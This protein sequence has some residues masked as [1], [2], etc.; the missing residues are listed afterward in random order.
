MY[1]TGLVVNP[2]SH[3]AREHCER[4]F[5]LGNSKAVE[6]MQTLTRSHIARVT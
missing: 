1:A 4:A 3:R 2:S 5:E 6:N